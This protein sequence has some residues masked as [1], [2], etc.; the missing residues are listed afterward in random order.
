LF[1]GLRDAAHV[2]QYVFLVF[3][4][5]CLGM[6]LVKLVTNQFQAQLLQRFGEDTYVSP[7]HPDMLG[8]MFVALAVQGLVFFLANLII[9][10]RS[11]AALRSVLSPLTSPHSGQCCLP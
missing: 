3:P 11:Q 6:G 5:Y 10:S 4:Q 1:Q 8:W 9:Q 2:L 7:S